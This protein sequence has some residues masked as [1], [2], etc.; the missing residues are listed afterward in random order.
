MLPMIFIRNNRVT[1][2]FGS[3][4]S[5]LNPFVLMGYESD[6]DYKVALAFRHRPIVDPSDYQLR[7]LASAKETSRN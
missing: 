4:N 6:G 3:G 2:A 7:P 1:R 5:Q